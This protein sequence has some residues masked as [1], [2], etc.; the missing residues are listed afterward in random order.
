L[1]G[2]T[3]AFI[4]IASRMS[5]MSWNG[6]EHDGYGGRQP[7]QHVVA[8][9][10]LVTTSRARVP[11]FY[12]HLWYEQQLLDLLAPERIGENICFSDVVWSLPR[13]S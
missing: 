9:S 7:G 12:V 5:R 3:H 13:A 4:A 10:S 2:Q 8:Y 11:C 6:K 1:H